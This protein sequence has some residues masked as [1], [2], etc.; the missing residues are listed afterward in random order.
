MG[1]HDAYINGCATAIAMAL[2]I[3]EKKEPT[4]R[5]MLNAF[6]PEPQQVDDGP[7]SIREAT[8][9]EVVNED[10]MCLHIAQIFSRWKPTQ[11]NTIVDVFETDPVNG[12]RNLATG[13]TATMTVWLAL[14]DGHNPGGT[15]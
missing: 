15:I 4:V 11:V 2:G 5:C 6:F 9:E 1:K 14:R 12:F 7:C 3:P 8:Q 10:N 13:N